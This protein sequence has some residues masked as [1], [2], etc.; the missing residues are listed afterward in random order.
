MDGPDI[1]P[2]RVSCLAVVAYASRLEPGGSL[3]LNST[4][5]TRT[6][7]RSPKPEWLPPGLL[8]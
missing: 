1:L 6:K 2:F 3:R 8:R 4:P 7:L 5:I